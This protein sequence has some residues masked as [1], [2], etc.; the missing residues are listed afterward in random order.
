MVFHGTTVGGDPVVGTTG[1]TLVVNS[2]TVPTLGACCTGGGGCTTLSQTD[3]TAAG[4][5]YAGDNTSCLTA[6]CP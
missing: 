2:C 1:G 6:V 3:C 4:G 5:A